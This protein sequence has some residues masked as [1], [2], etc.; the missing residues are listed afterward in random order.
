MKQHSLF[1]EDQSSASLSIDEA[2]GRLNVSSA[3]IRNWIK[4][5]HLQKSDLNTIDESSFE[6]FR[7]N[8]IGV[9]RLTQR[10]NKSVKDSHDHEKLR[11][12]IFSS[13]KQDRDSIDGLSAFYEGHLSEA[14]KNREGVFYTP[15]HI[16][17]K[18]F[19]FL[20]EDCS[21]LTFCDPCCGTG[22]FLVAAIERG[23]HPA[24][25]YG[26]DTDGVALEIA[27]AR[28]SKLDCGG[29]VTLINADFL[30][31]FQKS[32][33]ESYDV[34][35]TN[36]PWGKKISREERASLAK[37]LG[38][39]SK[40]DSS[41][42]FLF[43]C[44]AKLRPSGIL[45]LLL[46]DAF[47]NIA[48]FEGARRHALR[49]EIKALI[50]FGK[51]FS[52]LVTNAKGI[53]LRKD[54][55]CLNNA[56]RCESDDGTWY[57]PQS[58]FSRNPKAIFNFDCSADEA[59][60][61]EHLFQIEHLT[62][63]GFAKYGLGIVTGDN[64]R[65]CFSNADE[66]RVPVYKGSDIKRSGLK[67][68]SLYISQDMSLYQQVAPIGLYHADEKL[69]YKF[70]SAELVFFCD[71]ERRFILNS[72]NMLVLNED[73][74]ITHSQLCKLLNSRLMSWLFK[75]SFATHKVLRGDLE[76]LPIFINFFE[77]HGDFTE[78]TFLN[79]LGLEEAPIGA[80]RI[81]R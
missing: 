20:P 3:S 2:A 68:P 71:T 10:A 62:L 79:F 28:L 43:S 57:R 13:I 69:I 35:M 72:A 60:I 12:V 37:I 47:F 9:S 76:S 52:G 70:I 25:V 75:K 61:I 24:N 30:R 77:S 4:S 40:G 1:N 45:G 15:S 58:D 50:D 55:E 67:S 16:I 78:E 49:Y 17:E 41:S 73:F 48:A 27:R 80:Y 31:S 74:P 5:G 63:S 33:V 42:M 36:P 39:V 59:R 7:K 26:I 23:F 65:F 51:P 18:L 66:G 19:E 64:K 81:K 22:N 21:E 54:L 6:F 8:T 32:D 44:L 38:E 14:Y 56:L 11:D 53:V 29:K 34:I 46:Q